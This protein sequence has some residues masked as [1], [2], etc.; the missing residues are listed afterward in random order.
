SPQLAAANTA[1]KLMARLGGAEA[2]GPI[3]VG[4]NKPLHVLETGAD[5][6]DIVNVAIMA[7]VDAQNVAA[8]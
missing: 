7:V 6:R 2:I 5:V 3:L 1:Y 8:G 4:M